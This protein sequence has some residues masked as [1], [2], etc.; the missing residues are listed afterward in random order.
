MDLSMLAN[1]ALYVEGAQEDEDKKAIWAKL[2]GKR[3]T[4][5]HGEKTRQARRKGEKKRREVIKKCLLEFHEN[6]PHREN[7]TSFPFSINILRNGKNYLNALTNQ[8][9]DLESSKKQLEEENLRLTKRFREL[10]HTMALR[11]HDFYPHTKYEEDRCEVIALSSDSEPEE[12]APVKV[13]FREP[14][15]VPQL[16]PTVACQEITVVSE[17]TEESSLEY[18]IALPREI[19]KYIQLRTPNSQEIRPRLRRSVLDLTS[20][21]Y[22][23]INNIQRDQPLNLSLQVKSPEKIPCAVCG[24]TAFNQSCYPCSPKVGIQLLY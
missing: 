11:D 12:P 15:K 2:D 6:L 5:K 13:E 17:P 10:Q 19:P 18:L 4:R 22:D 1:A 7:D 14:Y 21:K 16:F 8:G 3:K 20:E 23:M 24:D 9:A